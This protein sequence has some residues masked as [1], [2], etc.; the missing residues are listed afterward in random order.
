MKI[1]HFMLD[2]NG[3]FRTLRCQQVREILAGCRT[4][5]VIGYELQ[6]ATAVCNE[7]LT[8]H[9]I[10]LLRLPLTDGVFT[11]DDRF[12]LQAFSRPDCVTAAEVALHHL[13]GWPR[14]LMSQLAVALDVSVA[15]VEQTLEVCGPVFLAAVKGIS[16]DRAMWKK[17]GR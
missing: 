9:G 2:A 15:Q 11:A 17:G 6:L 10:Y 4:P 3:Q 5:N 16:V 1:S 13:S 12:V 7:D 14:D 8:P